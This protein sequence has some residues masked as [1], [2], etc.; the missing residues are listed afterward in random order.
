MSLIPKCNNSNGMPHDV[1]NVW[2][3]ALYILRK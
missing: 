3:N 1:K 2:C